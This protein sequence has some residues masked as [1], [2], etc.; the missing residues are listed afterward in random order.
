MSAGRQDAA[1]RYWACFLTAS[2]AGSVRAGA[3]R[4]LGEVERDSELRGR[5]LATWKEESHVL[6]WWRLLGARSYRRGDLRL[7]AALGLPWL[8]GGV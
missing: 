4:E 1:S 6:M 2:G 3:R 5:G 8:S 7:R